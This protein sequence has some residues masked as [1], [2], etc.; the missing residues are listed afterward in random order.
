MDRAAHSLQAL[1]P[2]ALKCNT[3]PR[4]NQSCYCW[5]CF[6]SSLCSVTCQV[7]L[8]FSNVEVLVHITII[9]MCWVQDRSTLWN[10]K[11]LTLSTTDLPMKIGAWSPDFPFR[12]TISSLVLLSKWML[13][14]HHSS[15]CSISLLYTGLMIISDSANNS[16][17]IDEFIAGV[18]AVLNQAVH[19]CKEGRTGLSTQPRGT[20]VLMV[21]EGEMLLPIH[22]D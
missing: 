13:L 1:H 7:S 5:R 17:V 6:W 11:L 3:S 18:D 22:T 10:L 19:R 8:N 9:S 15:R 14:C 12:S 21:I 16:G 4:C 2:C 20:S